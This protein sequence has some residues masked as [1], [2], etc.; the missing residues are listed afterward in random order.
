MPREDGIFRSYEGLFQ[1]V[2]LRY[3]LLDI[4]IDF[5]PVFGSVGLERYAKGQR[6][7]FDQPLPLS[8]CLF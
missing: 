2:G 1:C 6:G 8:V 7:L 4:P 3:D 5:V